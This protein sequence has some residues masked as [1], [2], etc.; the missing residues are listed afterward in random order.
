MEAGQEDIPTEARLQSD[1]A[2]LKYKN[3]R[4]AQEVTN[5]NFCVSEQ[6]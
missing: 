5:V 3:E 1:I 4:L 6:S 2:A